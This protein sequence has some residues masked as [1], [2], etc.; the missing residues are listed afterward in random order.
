MALPLL[1][2][3]KFVDGFV[4]G[5]NLFR[6]CSENRDKR[7]LFFAD[8]VLFEEMNGTIVVNRTLQWLVSLLLRSVT[9]PDGKVLVFGRMGKGCSK[10]IVQRNLFIGYLRN[11]RPRSFIDLSVRRATGGGKID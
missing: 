7:K 4:L 8:E 5:R 3:P 1:F 2:N 11:E 6:V 9:F 10:V